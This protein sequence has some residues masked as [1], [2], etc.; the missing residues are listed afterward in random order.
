MTE[1]LGVCELTCCICSHY[2]ETAMAKPRR[3]AQ[4]DA[5]ILLPAPVPALAGAAPVPDCVSDAEEPEPMPGTIVVVFKYCEGA[6]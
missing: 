4:M 2:K 5:C 6:V 1:L 3:S